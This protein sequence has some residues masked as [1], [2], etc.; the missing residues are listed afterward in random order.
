[1]TKFEFS[2][3]TIAMQI[4]RKATTEQRTRRKL[5]RLV[6]DKYNFYRERGG[7][8]LLSKDDLELLAPFKNALNL[9]AEQDD[10]ITASRTEV[11][12]LD[13]LAVQRLANRQR[14]QR[15]IIIGLATAGALVTALAIWALNSRAIAQRERTTALSAG[16]TSQSIVQMR[17]FG[18]ATQAVRLAEAGLSIR[19]TDDNIKAF[20]DAIFAP[21]TGAPTLFYTTIATEVLGSAAFDTTGLRVVYDKEGSKNPPQIAILTPTPNE[22][23]ST[24]ANILASV[25]TFGGEGGDVYHLRTPQGTTVQQTPLRQM[26]N[27]ARLF[28]ARERTRHS[29]DRSLRVVVQKAGAKVYSVN[30]ARELYTLEPSAALLQAG[31]TPNGTYAYTLTTHSLKF[32]N[33]RTGD[34]V[35]SRSIIATP[36][37]N[38]Q[39]GTFTKVAFSQ[40]GRYLILTVD[41]ETRVYDTRPIPAVLIN[42]F[43][44]SYTSV[45]APDGNSILVV[46]ELEGRLYDRNG[47]LIANLHGHTQ[48]ITCAQFSPD[49]RKIL[50]ASDD[51]T[52]RVW[53]TDLR[54]E[55]YLAPPCR[56]INV[57]DA[58]FAATNPPAVVV[59]PIEGAERRYS[60]EGTFLDTLTVIPIDSRA[61]HGAHLTILGNRAAAIEL[62]DMRGIVRATLALPQLSTHDTVKACAASAF[63]G[64]SEGSPYVAVCTTNRLLLYL[65][66]GALVWQTPLE[67]S[68]G[69]DAWVSQIEWSPSGKRFALVY[70]KPLPTVVRNTDLA[71]A[72]AIYEVSNAVPLVLFEKP[73]SRTTTFE[74]SAG[75]N[76]CLL[77]G[78]SDDEGWN[79]LLVG[80]P[81]RAAAGQEVQK[82]EGILAISPNEKEMIFADNNG[83]QRRTVAPH[84]I[85]IGATVRMSIET[86]TYSPSGEVLAVARAD[87]DEAYLYNVR[88]STSKRGAAFDVPPPCIAELNLSILNAESG[89][90]VGDGFEPRILLRFSPDGSAI[91]C[92][93]TPSHAKLFYLDRAH[94]LYRLNE[95]HVDGLSK[96]YRDKFGL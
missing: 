55:T 17:Q 92:A 47:N 78:S 15:N 34:A 77:G 67:G 37:P 68:V 81:H 60:L 35:P 91:V 54:A 84:P 11:A 5:E 74:W 46:N 57:A 64:A 25:A 96:A 51:G 42:T 23:N 38:S 58:Y 70:E 9:P 36:A 12:R 83:W 62:L 13:A 80:I 50:T 33:A 8:G 39:S 52:V 90:M 40:D 43:P 21:T 10:Y 3:D 45:I 65:A 16:L 75:E 87:R 28:Y 49:S 69:K 44:E 19:Q 95:Y 6:N 85:R 73:K 27:E 63:L 31:F 24:A 26:L 94:F 20:Y 56:N 4:F 1:M 30:P 14:L 7:Q 2:H 72:C 89:D 41:S 53:Y 66:T 79:S 18:D 76:Y 61:T 86:A 93:V 82:W 88:P 29:P 22:R 59:E 32:W 71:T 48:A